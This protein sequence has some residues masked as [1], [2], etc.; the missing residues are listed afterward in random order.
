MKCCVDECVTLLSP[1]TPGA[2]GAAVGAGA[3]AVGLT[4][5]TK[6]KHKNIH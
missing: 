3:A 5:E 4:A 1:L 2:A 6:K